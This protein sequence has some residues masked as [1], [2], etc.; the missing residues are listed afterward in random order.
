M[1]KGGTLEVRTREVMPSVAGWQLQ[2]RLKQARVDAQMTRDEVADTLDWSISKLLRI[3][4]G[5][6]RVTKV[7]LEALAKLYDLSVKK[8]DE[9]IELAKISRQPTIANE[10]KDVLTPEF[11]RWIEFE[12]SADYIRQ[13]ETTLIPGIFQNDGYAHSVMIAYSEG[14]PEDVIER[15]VQARF[16]RAEWLLHR[17]GPQMWFIIDESALRRGIGNSEHNRDFSDMLSVLDNLKRFNTVGRTKRGEQI[18][19]DLNP[20]VSIQIVP[21]EVGA[22]SALPAPFEILEFDDPN[23]DLMAYEET[24]RGDFVI[25]DRGEYVT[26]FLNRFYATEKIAPPAEQTP[27]L[28]DGIRQMIM[29]GTN[30]IHFQKKENASVGPANGTEKD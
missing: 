17:D 26:P 18:E 23:Q 2:T 15:K 13:Y 24:R 21:F 1:N 20:S 16:I 19:D 11:R 4:N 12:L 6:S 27:D 29:S 9:M 25:Q 30:G 22:Y 8:T 14:Q 10:F 5:N 7:D 28:I 3:E